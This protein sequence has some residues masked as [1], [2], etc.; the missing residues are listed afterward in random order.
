MCLWDNLFNL[1]IMSRRILAA[2]AVVILFCITVSAQVRITEFM[3]NNTHSLTDED[4]STNQDW[5]EIQNFSA[6]NVNLLDWSL[7][8]NSGNPAKW[9]FP[10]T[11]IAPGNFVIIFASN[12]D[13]AIA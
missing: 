9:Q 2:F 10:A 3:A 7:T 12:K 1:K 13:R 4:G 5:I 11:N 8:D 6:T